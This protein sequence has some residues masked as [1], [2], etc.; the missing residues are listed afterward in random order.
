MLPPEATSCVVVRS[1][2]GTDP[3][4]DPVEI[5]KIGV[6]ARLCFVPGL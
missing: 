4:R 1:N 2:T 3:K 5:D 6:W